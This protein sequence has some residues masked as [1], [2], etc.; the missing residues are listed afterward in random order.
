MNSKRNLLGIL[1]ALAVGLF[2]LAPAAQAQES[3]SDLSAIREMWEG[4]PLTVK[5]SGNRAAGLADFARAFARAYPS[6]LTDA[7]VARLNDPN[8]TRKDPNTFV[9]DPPHGYL[10]YRYAMDGGAWLELC[11]WTLPKGRRMVAVSM[12]DLYSSDKEGLLAFY[13]YDPK[14]HRMSPITPL[15]VRRGLERGID[16]RIVE[17]PRVGYDIHLYEPSDRRAKPEVL[18]WVKGTTSFEAE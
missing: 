8:N 3:E 7:I 15:P 6:D 13:D 2:C 5:I 1:L 12:V 4:Q 11:Y 10:K 9:F 14:T 18:K 17:L 16:G